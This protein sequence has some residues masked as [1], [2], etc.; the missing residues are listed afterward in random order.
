MAYLTGVNAH[1]IVWIAL[2]PIE[3]KGVVSC[4][5]WTSKANT[6]VNG[7]KNS[8]NCSRILAVDRIPRYW[9]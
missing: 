4:L 5:L 3:F 9:P 6:L 8:S 7:R 1:L 2:T